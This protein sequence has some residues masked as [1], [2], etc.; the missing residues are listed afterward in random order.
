MTVNWILNK[1]IR[2]L[3][4]YLEAEKKAQALTFGSEGDQKESRVSS[5]DSQCLFL[6]LKDLTRS[7]IDIFTVYI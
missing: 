6:L 7:R 2:Q 3:K 1:M 5:I 4:S